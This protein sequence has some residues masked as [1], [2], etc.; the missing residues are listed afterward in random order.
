MKIHPPFRPPLRLL[1]IDQFIRTGKCHVAG[2]QTKTGL[3]PDCPALVRKLGVS[4]KT[5]LRDIGQLREKGADVRFSR[6]E[7]GYYYEDETWRLE[8]VEVSAGDLFALLMAEQVVAQYRGSPIENS[9]RKIHTRLRSV[10]GEH[11]EEAP[12]D[13]SWAVTVVPA[14][15]PA[16]KPQVWRPILTGLLERRTVLVKYESPW[17]KT[18]EPEIELKPYHIVNLENE[19]Y[20]LAAPANGEK[21]D[22]YQYSMAR[23]CWASVTQDGFEVPK[24]LDVKALLDVTFGRF[25]S[26]KNLCKVRLRFSKKVAPLVRARHWHSKQRLVVHNNGDVVLSFPVSKAGAWPLYHVRSWV[27]GWGADVKVL[28]PKSLRDDVKKEATRITRE[29]S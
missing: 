8:S 3:Y 12:E 23:M 28:A 1:A 17:N 26:D 22:K 6:R 24:D 7:G 29:Y 16:T 25:V 9:V 27:L 11:G 20:L 15:T 5:I 21:P 10:M 18:A 4:K 13:L 2:F 19:W 14:P